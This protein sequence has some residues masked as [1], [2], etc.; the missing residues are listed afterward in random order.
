M[1]YV[2]TVAPTVEPFELAEAKAH[3]RVDFDDDDA[4]IAGLI[5]AV[6]QHFEK[7]TRRA[8][9]N[10]TWRATFWGFPRA[11]MIRPHGPLRIGK[12]PISAISEIKYY[13][14]ANVLRTLDAAL[15]QV[16]TTG[17]IAEIWPA[18]DQ[19]WPDFQRRPDAVQVTFVA[20][21]GAAAANIPQLFKQC[22]LLLLGHWYANREIM[23]AGAQV[24]APFTVAN[25]IE[26][27]TIP[28]LG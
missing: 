9:V 25:I 19:C 14:S 23:L 21:Y 2:L 8:L 17:E 3:L 10:Q 7:E 28:L 16:D 11:G 24:Q 6:R 18:V 20:G 26:D 13:D 1:G 12:G 27:N 22:M 15:Y 5:V 4:T